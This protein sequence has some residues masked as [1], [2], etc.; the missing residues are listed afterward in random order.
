MNNTAICY[1]Q[2][3]LPEETLKVE[4]V[5]LPPCP[6]G[7]LR[8][9]MLC[10]PIN[11]SDLIPV[12]GA[13]SHRITP[14]VV[15]G[16]EGVGVVISAPQGL[17][18]LTGKRVLPLRGEGTWQTNIDCDP[19]WAV[20]VPDEIDTALAARAYINPLAALLMLRLYSPAGKR[21]LLTAAGSDCALLLGQWALRMGAVSVAGIH[22]SAVHAQ[23]L[24]DCG[25]TPV[26]QQDAQAVEC[27][28]ARSDLVFDATGGQLAETL[29]QT[30]PDAALFIC[31]GLLSGQPFR[32][33]RRL[34]RMHWFHIRN[35]LDDLT[36]ARWQSLFSEIWA[37][38]KISRLGGIRRFLQADWQEAMAFYR[39]EGRTEKPMLVMGEI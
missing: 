26:S 9:R 10:A 13:Y 16:Y 32:Q 35:Y 25:I 14:P 11:A 17:G 28:A 36:P 2:F 39:A 27:I 34:P 4:S 21:V 15:A 1:R 20:L 6:A 38:L 37:L 8:V 12:T 29:L 31:Y 3:G 33:T 18:H 22:R 19:G 23:R 5:P 30:L 7:R 24:I